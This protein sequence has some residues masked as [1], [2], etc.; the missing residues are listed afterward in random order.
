M[1]TER[2]TV[3]TLIGLILQDQGLH[4]LPRP[5]CQKHTIWTVRYL[6]QKVDEKDR[7][8]V[9][10]KAELKTLSIAAK[11]GVEAVAKVKSLEAE[12]KKLGEETV[13]LTKNFES[14]RVRV[15]C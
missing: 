13:I 10:V 15:C 3:L 8:L 4:C 12:N 1:Q 9:K 5:I 7:D 6:F 2:Q 11:D 14:E